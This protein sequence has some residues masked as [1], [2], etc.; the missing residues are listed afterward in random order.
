LL[1]VVEVDLLVAAA[2]VVELADLEPA[3]HLQ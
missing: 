2:A 1:L 3:L